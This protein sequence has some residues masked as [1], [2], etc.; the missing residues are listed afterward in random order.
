MIPADIWVEELAFQAVHVADLQQ[1]LAI[2]HHPHLY[3]SSNVFDAGW[4]IGPHPSDR[5]VYA[6]MAAEAG[7]HAGVTVLFSRYAS[8]WL[9]R[10]WE[11][12]TISVDGA[13]IAHNAKLGL[14]VRF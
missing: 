9:A 2:K 4:A 7:L 5:Q 8:P 14:Q 12:V 1:T 6:Y 10:V 13:T 3:E 11:V